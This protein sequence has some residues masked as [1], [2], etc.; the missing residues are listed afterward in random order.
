MCNKAVDHYPHAS[1]VVPDY[2]TQKMCDKAVDTYLELLINVFLH[3][4]IFVI[5]I[6]LTKCVTEL[7]LKILLC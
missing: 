3:L 5:N 6:K 4:L 7:F 1:E 2:M